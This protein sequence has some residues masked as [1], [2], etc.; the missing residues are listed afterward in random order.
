MLTEQQ[1]KSFLE[2]SKHLKEVVKLW[3]FEV[4][5]NCN[6]N[7]KSL[8]QELVQCYQLLKSPELFSLIRNPRTRENFLASISKEIEKIERG[9]FEPED[10]LSDYKT[11]VEDISIEIIADF[12]DKKNTC[13]FEFRDMNALNGLLAFKSSRE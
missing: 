5:G 8:H 6:Y 1:K 7:Q 2:L 3:S 10:T 11:A 9:D 13:A 4:T 12:D